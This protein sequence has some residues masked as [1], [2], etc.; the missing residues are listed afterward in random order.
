MELLEALEDVPPLTVAGFE[1]VRDT[2]KVHLD[3]L[4]PDERT[5]AAGL[6]GITVPRSWNAVG[7][8]VTGT[9][10]SLES[11][12]TTGRA[13]SAM[14]VTRDG[15]IADYID[16]DGE[17]QI[18]VE[19]ASNSQG[20][21]AP[22]GTMVDALHRM[23]RLPSPGE[24]VDTVTVAYRLWVTDILF[25]AVDAGGITWDQ[26]ARLHPRIGDNPLIPP[27]VEM[28]VEASCRRD[29]EFNWG[30]IRSRMIA[31]N[32]GSGLTRKELKWM[33][34]TM[35]SRWAIGG[36]PDVQQV[37]GVLA[38]LGCVDV[39]RMVLEAVDGIR[40]RMADLSPEQTR[41]R[42]A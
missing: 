31:A 19:G 21:S 17:R 1:M 34:A 37:V 29:R 14:V 42:I 41:L 33:D 8:K 35:Y 20:G 7:V 25:D 39:A 10:R 27:S 11:G 24:A 5:G 28:V 18:E 2:V 12:E 40:A 6:F 23:L 22:E 3:P 9:A 13:E 32:G 30:R 26:A 4:R 15:E 38:E 16:V 36:F